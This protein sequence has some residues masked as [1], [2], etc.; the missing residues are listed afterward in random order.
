MTPARPPSR[1]DVPLL[2]LLPVL[3]LIVLQCVLVE[4]GARARHGADFGKLYYGVVQ[5][6]LY[7]PTPATERID[8]NGRQVAL[9][10]LNPPQVGLLVVP[11]AR[12][13]FEW[14]WAAWLLVQAA[15]AIALWRVSA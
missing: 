15:A 2:V 7:G 9:T 12:L 10:N 1:T 4:R 5:G 13:P 11:L 8:V 6:D 3:V 14:A